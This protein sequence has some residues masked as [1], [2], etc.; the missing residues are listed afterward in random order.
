MLNLIKTSILGP[1]LAKNV[2]F[3]LDPQKRALHSFWSGSFCIFES[4]RYSNNMKYNWRD[5]K[6]CLTFQQSTGPK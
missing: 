4:H 1:F 5:Y 2:N 3:G 6:L